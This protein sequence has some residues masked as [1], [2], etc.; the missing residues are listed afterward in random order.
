MEIRLARRADVL[1]VGRLGNRASYAAYAEVLDP[2]SLAAGIAAEYSARALAKCVDAESLVVCEAENGLL[3]GF[4]TFETE[5]DHLHLHRV[6]VDPDAP[7]DE[8]IERLLGWARE[9]DPLSAVSTDVTLGLVD[10]EHAYS[11]LGF[12]PGEILPSSVHGTDV[13]ERRWWAPPLGEDRFRGD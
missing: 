13:V 2:G 9:K 8:V 1:Q 7:A 10:Q 4:V 11:R 3:A 12:S 6:V 5:R